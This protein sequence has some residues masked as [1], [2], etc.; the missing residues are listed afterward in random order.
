[1]FCNNC[2]KEIDDNAVVCPHCGVAVNTKSYNG[3]SQF[4]PQ[5]DNNTIA[6]VGFVFSFL[7]A[8]VGLICSIVGFNKAKN[9]GAPHIGLALAGIIISAISM[10]LS[11]LF[12]VLII[13]AC[14]A[15]M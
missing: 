4:Q 11:V 2:G 1:M 6:I 8:L 10:G 7:F 3:Q 14:A 12:Y 9:E 15:L 13:P 5:A